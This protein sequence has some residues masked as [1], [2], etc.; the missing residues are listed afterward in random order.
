MSVAAVALPRKRTSS[1]SVPPAKAPRM[2]ASPLR[3]T[4]SHI[5]LPHTRSLQYYKEQRQQRRRASP[6]P[7]RTTVRQL[8]PKPVPRAL[9]SP[10]QSSPLAPTRTPLPSRPLFPRSK[11]EP[12]LYR[13]AL[14]TSMKGSPEGQKIL[15][16]GPH[17]AVS[18]MSATM[19]LERLVERAACDDADPDVEGDVLMRD[20]ASSP[21]DDWEML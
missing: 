5:D 2:A 1:F 6:A 21:L 7:A 4:E 13:K 16:M 18:I 10:R 11:P 15:C 20:A 9:L 19:E 17:L 3:R 12:D 8:A 14:R